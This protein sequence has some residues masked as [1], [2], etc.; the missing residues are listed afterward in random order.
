MGAVL[1]H[2]AVLH[3]IDTVRP[4]H[5]CQP[6]GDEDDRLLP[7]QAADDLHDHLLALRVNVGGGLVKDVHRRVVEQGPCQGQSLALAAGEVAAFFKDR[8]LKALLPGKEIPQS[9]LPQGLLHLLLP[10]V[11]RSHPQIVLHC[12]F[13][14]P[15]VMAHHGDLVHQAFLPDMGQLFSLYP[16]AASIASVPPHEDA[17][18]RALAAARGPHD[19]GKAPRRE[20][21]GHLV[22]YL[23]VLPVGEAHVLK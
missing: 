3:H 16:H 13:K 4:G 6:V 23:P 1:R 20:L 22:Q 9:D 21:H 5:I 18:R 7:G 15:A 2:P 12:A 10:G 11:R 19:G 8:G 17:G 14:E